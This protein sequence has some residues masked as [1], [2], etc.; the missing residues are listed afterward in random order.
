M[1][2]GQAGDEDT[3]DSWEN[4][5]G[6]EIGK[7]GEELEDKSE[8]RGRRKEGVGALEASRE[9]LKKTKKSSLARKLQ[10]NTHKYFTVYHIRDKV[11]YT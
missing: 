8:K 3:E 1:G 9:L 5:A 11:C 7:G 6:L 10:V 2:L 4:L